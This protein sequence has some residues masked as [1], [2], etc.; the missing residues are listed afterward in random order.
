M[1]FAL[2][3][4]DAIGGWRTIDEAGKP[5]EASGTTLGGATVQGLS[6]LRALLLAEREQ[7]PRTVTEKLM[8]YALGRRIEYFDQPAI[9][10]IAR[11]AEAN[12]YRMSSFILGVIKSDAFQMKRAEPDTTEDAVIRE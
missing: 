4:F 2:E 8:A 12:D 5:V 6:G 7:F 1:G 10:A 3:H 9:R 11:A